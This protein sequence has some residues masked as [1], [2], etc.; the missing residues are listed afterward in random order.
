M[1]HAELYQSL[2]DEFVRNGH[3]VTFLSPYDGESHWGQ[4]KNHRVLFFSSYKMRGTNLIRKAFSNIM[5]PFLS[6]RA[7]KSFINPLDFDLLLMS[8]PP[9]A[10]YKAVHYLK[11]MN[12]NLKFYLI[13]RDI[14]PEGAKFVGL[15]KIPLLYKYFQYQAK[16][17]YCDADIIGCMS[18]FNVK[19][20]QENYM[21]LSLEKVQL[22]PNWGERKDYVEPNPII[23]EKYG[24]TGKFIVIYGG[25]MGIMQN[26]TIILDLA[27]IKSSYKDVVFL[28]I[29]NGTEFLK[30]K[31]KIKEKNLLNVLLWNKL[32]QDEYEQIL[33]NSNLG[34][35]SLH[36]KSF[37]ANIPSKTISYFQNKIPILASIDALGDYKTYIVENS[38]AGLWS[39]ADD[40]D[41]LSENFDRLYFNSDLCKQMG[42]AGHNHFLKYFTVDSAYCSILQQ[43]NLLG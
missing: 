5:F 34:I 20:I 26:L 43:L 11:K 24:L 33:M 7:V 8:T 12:K 15:G 13:L 21:H 31:N 25:A 3:A 14:H 29:G 4:V 9:I 2:A 32:P 28:L 23:K 30:L 41:S 40:L 36:P 6:M 42:E 1:P 19:L 16:L 18:P 10:Y 27:E 39:L 35:I 22:L 37:F 38:K 17:L